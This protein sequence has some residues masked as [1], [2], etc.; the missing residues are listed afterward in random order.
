MKSDPVQR[1]AR[2]AVTGKGAH[3]QTREVF[4]GLDWKLAGAR[5]PGAPHSA[6]QLLE[7]MTFW[8]E[9]AARWLDGEDPAT[10]RHA[11]GSWPG[12][13]GP[14]TAAEW[15][16]AVKRFQRALDALER[17]CRAGDLLAKPGSKTALEM[18]Q[19]IGSHNS[20]HA[21]QVAML[22]QALGAWPPPSGGLTW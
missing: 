10:P 21:G 12:G 11:A 22:R 1:T 20:Y 18:L 17:R 7:H 19:T 2:G 9:W 8:Q 4:D 15:R 5:P 13:H 14:A 16:Q 3:A 6:C